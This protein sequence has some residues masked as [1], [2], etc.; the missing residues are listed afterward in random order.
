MGTR[1]VATRTSCSCRCVK[2]PWVLT[3]LVLTVHGESWACLLAAVVHMDVFADHNGNSDRIDNEEADTFITHLFWVG[4]KQTC[5]L[6]R[7][8][9][10]SSSSRNMRERE[11]LENVLDNDKVGSTCT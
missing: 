3:T 1:L 10:D 4:E 6:V 2:P 8:H 9:T 7:R 11:R 5:V